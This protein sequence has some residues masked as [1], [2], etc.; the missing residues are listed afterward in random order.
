MWRGG[1]GGVTNHPSLP[2]SPQINQTRIKTH[3]HTKQVE[4]G[5]SRMDCH[6]L[7]H[8]N[9]EAH[10]AESLASTLTGALQPM[11]PLFDGEAPEERAVGLLD[12]TTVGGFNVD[13]GLVWV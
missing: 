2:P 5:L 1:R 8:G 4:E 6:A 11:K 9:F 3:T 13:V 7:A 12:G 10:E